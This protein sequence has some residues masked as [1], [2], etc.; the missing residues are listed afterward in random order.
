MADLRKLF[1]VFA[2]S[3]LAQKGVLLVKIFLFGV[4][5]SGG[6]KVFKLVGVIARIWKA[7]WIE[8]CLTSGF[9][10]NLTTDD[11]TFFGSVWSEFNPVFFCLN[12]VGSDSFLESEKVLPLILVYDSSKV[13]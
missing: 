12:L 2:A 6:S 13:S 8:M 3:Y 11:L 4:V 7:D 10:V 5:E 1:N 9:C